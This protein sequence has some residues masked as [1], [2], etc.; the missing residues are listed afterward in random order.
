MENRELLA[1][2]SQIINETLRQMQQSIEGLN[3]KI[4]NEVAEIKIQI[5]SDIIKRLD[6]L[7]E[8]TNDVQL[9][10]KIPME[11]ER[12]KKIKSRYESQ[13]SHKASDESAKVRK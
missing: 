12:V 7:L 13:T 3:A 8:R 4:E 5:D 2:L 9:V 6:D 11:F 1:A 10:C